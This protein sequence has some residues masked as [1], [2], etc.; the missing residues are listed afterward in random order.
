MAEGCQ[1]A[2]PGEFPVGRLIWFIARSLAVDEKRLALGGFR[3]VVIERFESKE[4]S[5][6]E[7]FLVFLMEVM[8]L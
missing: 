2:H 5:D 6:G 3:L 4:F 7:F 1:I 8:V